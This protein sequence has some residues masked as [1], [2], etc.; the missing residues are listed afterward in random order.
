DHVIGT[1]PVTFDHLPRLPY[2]R[3][4]IQET[5][6]LHGVTF[7]DRRTTRA[8]E[9]SGYR[10]PAGTQIA[11]SFYA[12]GRHPRL[13][14]DPD[15]FWPGRPIT[16]PD[17][18]M[19][20]GSGLRRC[21]GEHYATAE[22]TSWLCAILSRWRLTIKKPFQPRALFAG[23]PRLEILPVIVTRRHE[24]K[25]WAV[26]TREGSTTPVARDLTQARATAAVRQQQNAGHHR[27]YAIDP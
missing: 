26:F 12:L 9:V 27:A 20:W 19:P 2:L 25:N 17:L 3:S 18:L 13:Y 6:R 5:M 15:A 21:P 10:L 16:A 22:I 1:D 23:M 8:T 24:P 4:V 11:I 14:R 7:V